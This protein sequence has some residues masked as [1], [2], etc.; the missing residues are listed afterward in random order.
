MFGSFVKNC[1]RDG[2]QNAKTWNS[3]KYR[4]ATV[5]KEKTVML[6]INAF[7]LTTTHKIRVFAKGNEI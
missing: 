7:R 3:F 5:S 4:H 6:K 2:K 1:I